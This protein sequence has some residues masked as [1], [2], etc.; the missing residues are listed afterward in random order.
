MSDPKPEEQSGWKVRAGPL[1]IVA[2]ALSLIEIAMVVLYPRL[3]EDWEKIPVLVVILAV[4]MAVVGAF[5]YLWIRRPGHLHSPSEFGTGE[6][7]VTKLAAFSCNRCGGSGKVGKKDCVACMGVGRV[8][9]L[10]FNKDK[11]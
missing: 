1:A 8:G 6:D 5:T 10:A 4:P 11:E 3:T 2:G 9:G 7:A